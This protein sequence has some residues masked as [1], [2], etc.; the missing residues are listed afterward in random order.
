R[1]SRGCAWLVMLHR[2][3][4]TWRPEFLNSFTH[5]GMRQPGPELVLGKPVQGMSARLAPDA[6]TVIL[7]RPSAADSY[8]CGLGA[9]DEAF[10]REVDRQ[11]GV[12]LAVSHAFD[13]ASADLGPQLD[14]AI[15]SGRL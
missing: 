1:S 3:N 7:P 4:G 14:T 15:R 10:H 13:P 8:S 9:E 11:H 5:A 12:M 2:D 6:V